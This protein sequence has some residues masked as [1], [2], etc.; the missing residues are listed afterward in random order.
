MCVCVCV[1][2]CVRVREREREREGNQLISILK[3]V[4][5]LCKKK[6]QVRDIVI[7]FICIVTF[8]NQS[9]HS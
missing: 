5:I 2:V 9:A 7:F 4:L 6:K 8:I 1:C 3:K